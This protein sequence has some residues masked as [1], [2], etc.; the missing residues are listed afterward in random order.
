MDAIF[1]GARFGGLVLISETKPPTGVGKRGLGT[2]LCQCACG[3]TV[4]VRVKSLLT[5]RVKTCGCQRITVKRPPKTSPTLPGTTFGKLTVL[6]EYCSLDILCF[7]SCGI[8]TVFRRSSLVRGD[9]KS[10]GCRAVDPYSL[11]DRQQDV[12]LRSTF[13]KVSAQVKARDRFTCVLCR[14]V[15]GDL[16]TH[17]IE[18]WSKN[19]DLRFDGRNLVTL[20]KRCHIDKA[21]GGSLKFGVTDPDI[22]KILKQYIVDIYAGGEME[23]HGTL[24]LTE[25][26][27]L[28]ILS[29]VIPE[30]IKRNWDDLSLSELQQTVNRLRN[31]G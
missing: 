24:E 29:G 20:C 8:E 7:C 10:C 31:K 3:S 19:K 12:F 16:H 9:A 21:H 23:K 11:N 15:G 4:E 18:P 22:A 1:K 30:R 17:H 13:G 14:V 27:Q 2:W 26:E 5:N 6:Q 28:L 25:E